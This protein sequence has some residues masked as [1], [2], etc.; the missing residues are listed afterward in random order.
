MNARALANRVLE[1]EDPKEIFRQFASRASNFFEPGE[2]IC[3]STGICHDV[4]EAMFFDLKQRDPAKYRELMNDEIEA[5]LQDENAVGDF[6]PEHFTYEQMPN[7][8]QKYCPPFTYF[9]TNEGDGCW[10]CWPYSTMDLSDNVD[11]GVLALVDHT[12]QERAYH[13]R[14]GDWTGVEAPFALIVADNDEQELWSK[15]TR[16]RVWKW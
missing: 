1:G 3:H 7:V 13:I 16:R 9:G 12:E 2:E 14:Q 4:L 11:E 5:Y 10:G 6:D 15:T 8:M